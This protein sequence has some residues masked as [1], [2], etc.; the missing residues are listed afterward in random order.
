RAGGGK[1][2]KNVRDSHAYSNSLQLH[3]EKGMGMD[4]KLFG[5]ILLDKFEYFNGQNSKGLK[6]DGDARFGGEHKNYGSKQKESARI[7]K[8]V[9][10]GWKHYGIALSQPIGAPK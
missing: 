9:P 2:H 4:G 5:S 6:F 3:H 8:L 1:A 10:P 7:M